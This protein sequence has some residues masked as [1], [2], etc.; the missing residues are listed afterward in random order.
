MKALR[1]HGRQ[2][3][4]LEDVEFDGALGAGMV[5]VAVDYCGICGSDLAEFQHGP[6][7]IR[8]GPHRLTGQGP[9]VTLGHEFS[10]TIVA[11]G[12]DV[13]D[14]APE[15]RVSAD[16]TWRCGHCPACRQGKYNLCPDGGSIG[17][18]SDG[19]FAARVRIPAYCAV[20]LPEQVSPVA[21]SLIEPLSVGLHAL[22]RGA[23]QAGD[24][25]VIT[26]FGPIG[27]ATAEV[28][29]ALGLAV[30]VVEP[31][32]LR[33]QRAEDLGYSAVSPEGEPRDVAR[34]IRGLTGGGA[35]VVV[36]CSGNAAALELA[37]ELSCR[38]GRIVS[39]GLP[40]RPVPIDGARLVLY[41]RSLIGALGYVF[42]LPRIVKMIDSGA[43]EPERLVTRTVALADAVTEFARLADDAGADLK[44]LV[45]I[46]AQ[47]S[48]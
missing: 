21:G 2:D 3:V 16:A 7:A 35:P 36:E 48:A 26:G 14:L 13:R 22:D 19:G 30:L 34:T 31:N 27:A 47:G 37:P 10:G 5:E 25:V 1:W 32:A 9:P 8:P 12:A 11:V 15:L 40:K 29:T 33:R 45:S 24:S 6:F 28:A 42:D 46:G 17:L 4:R 20:P 23:V 38:G 18:A 41:E 44:V 39:V 43:L